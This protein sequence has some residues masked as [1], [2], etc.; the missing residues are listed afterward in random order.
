MQA[1]RQL[2]WEQ[3][4]VPVMIMH[5]YN[6]MNSWTLS[7]KCVYTFRAVMGHILHCLQQCKVEVA[8]PEERDSTACSASPLVCC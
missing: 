1:Y 8:G 4:Q 3:V 7:D 2:F 6:A 5:C